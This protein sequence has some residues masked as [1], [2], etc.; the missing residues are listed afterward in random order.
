MLQSFTTDPAILQAV[1]KNKKALPKSSVFAGTEFDPAANAGISVEDP[2]ITV[3]DSLGSFEGDLQTFQQQ[4]RVQIAM[5]A[6]LELGQYLIGIP[7]RKN[8]VWFAGNFPL[9][10]SA[11]PTGSDPATDLTPDAAERRALIDTYIQGRISVYPVSAVGLQTDAFTSA[12]QSNRAFATNPANVTTASIQQASNRANE[13][14]PMEKLAE[15]TGGKAF[16]DTNGLKQAIDTAVSEG[17][18]FYSLAYVPADHEFDQKFHKIDV[19]VDGN[20]KIS[21]RRGYYADGPDGVTPLTASLSNSYTLEDAMARGVPNA[22]SIIFKIHV[23]AIQKPE[24]SPLLGDQVATLKG[25][26]VRYAIDY[27]ASMRAMKIT[28]TSDGV[29]H[30]S[31]TFAAV[32]YDID[33]RALNSLTQ[34]I[35]VDMKPEAVTKYL[36]SGLKYEQVIDL[37]E[38]PLFLKVGISDPANGKIGTMEIPLQPKALTTAT[39][40]ATK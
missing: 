12:S 7:G 26:T 14:I 11:G 24:G 23:E 10:L 8:L 15:D 4:Q 39:S 33:D 32:G 6:L 9:G 38:T 40:A 17:E 5:E 19:A 37:P 27:A 36:R 13:R 29:R 35:K 22:T 16:F 31:L 28:K 25:K 21:Y 3:A 34:Q 18:H 20:Y 2:T 1:I 30:A